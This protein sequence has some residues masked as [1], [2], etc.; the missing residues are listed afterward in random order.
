MTARIDTL[1]PRHADFGDADALLQAA[2][3]ACAERLAP[4]RAVTIAVNDP[5]RA[6]RTGAVLAALAPALAPKAVRV[7]VACGTHRFAPEARRAFADP[8]ARILPGCQIAWHDCLASDLVE[9][10]TAPPWRAHPWLMDP[11][12]AL[13]AIGSVEVHY[14]AGLTGA[15][16][17]VTVG[18]GDRASIEANHAGALS[19]DSR[20]GRL[21][22]NPV[23]EGIAAMLAGLEAR[24][25]VVAL[26]L[27]QA[28]GRVLSAS[29]GT[30]TEALEALAPQA[31]ALGC[32]EVPSPADALVLEADGVLGASFYQADKAV[33]NSEWAIRDG[34]CAV[35]VAPCPEG[36]GQDHFMGLLA[37]CPTYRS[38]ADAVGRDGYRLGDHKAV[39]LRYLTDRRGVRVF[40]VSEGL[41]D[42][43]LRVLGFARSP[44]VEDALTTAGIDPARDV[45]YRVPDAANVSV[46]VAGG[47][48]RTRAEG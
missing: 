14:F 32:R 17:T 11:S 13:L 1:R 23:H 9:I 15:H 45:V 35:L 19:A 29:A 44:T 26:N 16:K 6:T 38:A 42:E 28:G 43:D 25:D 33:K 27:L 36:I 39:K 37:R 12:W 7:L 41:S 48:D 40:A 47:F 34:G 22:G 2:V 8:L 31:R 30:P 4:T 18:C 3:D 46:T 20:P 10:G 24:R 21:A 5:Q